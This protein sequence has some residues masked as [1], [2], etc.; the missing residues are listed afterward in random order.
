MPH[1][2]LGFKPKKHDDDDLGFKP[3][4]QPAP[5]SPRFEGG[6]LERAIYGVGRGIGNLASGLRDAPLAAISPL[7]YAAKSAYG[8]YDN[9]RQHIGQAQQ[10]PSTVGK[11][12]EYG[13]AVP[14]LGP[15]GQS[16]GERSGQGDVS[17]AISEGLTTTIL[18]LLLGRAGS[19]SPKSMIPGFAKNR[20]EFSPTANVP[21]T[22]GGMKVR[23]RPEP[24][25]N[26]SP[27]SESPYYPKIQAARG[28]A[29]QQARTE[30]N[31]PKGK[32]SLFQPEGFT[33][34]DV[35]SGRNYPLPQAQP[36]IAPAST[37]AAKV[38][39]VTGKAKPVGRSTIVTP[40]STP[41]AVKGSYWS[42]PEQSLRKAVLTGDRAAATV[43]MQRFGSL[44]EGA[45]LLTDVGRNPTRGLY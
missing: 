15:L 36:T 22:G 21:F 43:Y 9:A 11:L 42:F 40:G 24:E 28:V 34:S 10:E 35:T 25:A 14:I 30:L 4:S 3:S 8:M 41:P 44:P 1:D 12:A 32:P 16:L 6:T 29:R 37:G 31:P 27:L 20:V 33:R 26:F 45:S 2:D 38:E 39:Y 23:L 17:G 7:A 19:V 5:E 13:A 18:P